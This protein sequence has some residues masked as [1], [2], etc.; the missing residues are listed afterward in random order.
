MA[1]PIPTDRGARIATLAL[2]L[3]LGVMWLHNLQWKR[4]PDFGNATGCCLKKY[5]N[6]AVNHE[7]WHPFALFVDNVVQK[8]FVAF[9]WITIMTET[10]LAIGLLLGIATRF[11]G[12]VGAFQSIAIGL[13]ALAVPNEWPYSYYLMFVAHLGVFALAAG[14][15]G[16]LDAIL[17]P[18][19]RSRRA[20][21]RVARL[22][23]VAS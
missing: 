2:R 15:V 9:G 1:E 22:L 3:L 13:S 17:R 10:A 23:T 12:L 4:P 20:T 11:W 21:S 6:A 18:L 16:G 8:H 14:R 7:V 5:A 19:W